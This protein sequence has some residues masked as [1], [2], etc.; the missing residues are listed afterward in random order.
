MHLIL[1]SQVSVELGVHVHHFGD[2]DFDALDVS[3]TVPRR[4]TKI[5][6]IAQIAHVEILDASC[7][8][9]QAHFL[10]IGD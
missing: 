9:G 3:I 7:M 5:T 4:H 2:G 6:A 1:F 8:S 10:T